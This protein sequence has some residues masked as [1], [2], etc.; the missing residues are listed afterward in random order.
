MCCWEGEL[1]MC[2]DCQMGLDWDS[3]DWD[4]VDWE[5][6]ETNAGCMACDWE[7]W[8]ETDPNCMDCDACYEEVS[9]PLHAEVEALMA[10]CDTACPEE[11]GDMN[12]DGPGGGTAGG[13]D[14]TAPAMNIRKLLN[15][16]YH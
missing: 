12:D 9:A 4:S 13:V 16:I 15:K 10:Q 8:T 6:C 14:T 2:C 5:S 1:D 11:G 3:I 7:N